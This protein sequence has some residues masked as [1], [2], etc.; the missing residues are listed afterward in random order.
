ME[1]MEAPQPRGDTR[2][3]LLPCAV[4]AARE[5]GRLCVRV[6]AQMAAAAGRRVRRGGK[7]VRNF[8]APRV[9][10]SGLLGGFS[11][12]LRRA[13]ARE[14]VGGICRK[15]VLRGGGE[16]FRAQKARQ[17]GRVLFRNPRA[18]RYRKARPKEV[19]RHKGVCVRRARQRI[20]RRARV[21]GR[22]RAPTFSPPAAPS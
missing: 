17:N 19:R 3:K 6:A 5:G 1:R 8:R 16:N 13:V 2:P 15:A 10:Y 9:L 20:F 22:P 12:G 11:R 4:F 21:C 18:A 7:P 14:R